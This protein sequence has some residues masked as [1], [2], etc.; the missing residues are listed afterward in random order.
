MKGGAINGYQSNG[1]IDEQWEKSLLGLCFA[2]G[3]YVYS[4]IKT[5]NASVILEFSSSQLNIW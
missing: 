4:C 1:G 3:F 5:C 2:G